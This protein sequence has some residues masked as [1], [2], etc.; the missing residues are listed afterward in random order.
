[1]SAL[2]P[3]QLS[4]LAP[5]QDTPQQALLSKAVKQCI[6]S[7]CD[8]LI[9]VIRFEQAISNIDAKWGQLQALLCSLYVT[10]LQAS[11][12]MEKPLFDFTVVF[13][14]WAGYNVGLRPDLKMI[15]TT[16]TQD[17][18]EAQKLNTERQKHDIQTMEVVTLPGYIDQSIQQSTQDV[19]EKLDAFDRVAVGGTFDHLHAGH[20]ILLTMT[21][22]LAN[23]SVV[24]GVTDDVMLQSK[25]FHDQ[26]ESID[27]RINNVRAFLDTIRHGLIFDIVPITDP[28]GPTIT[29]STIQALVC[30]KETEKGGDAVNTERSKR[31]FPPLALRLIDVISSDKV[32]IAGQDMVDLKISST[33]IRKYIAEHDQ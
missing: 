20:K 12:A 22:L 2:F 10:Q 27:Q 4:S 16:T 30:S 31:D 23:K 33:W 21:A 9:M 14:S 5:I 7:Q 24:V 25:K 1:M 11:Y 32:S 19:T 3:L 13:E 17:L 15:F 29:D 8:K 26:I 18:N 28:F 6:E